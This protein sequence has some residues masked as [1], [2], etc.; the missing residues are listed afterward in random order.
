[1]I[2]F[3]KYI[4]IDEFYTLTMK[5]RVDA[6]TDLS[7]LSAYSMHITLLCFL[8]LVAVLWRPMGETLDRKIK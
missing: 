4:H 8:I 3:R 5:I 1:M 6:G 2:F 7:W